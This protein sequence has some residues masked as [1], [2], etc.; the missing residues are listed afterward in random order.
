MRRTEIRPLA[1]P[2]FITSANFAFLR[3]RSIVRVVTPNQAAISSIGCLHH[4]E[5]FQLSHIDLRRCSTL[6]HFLKLLARFTLLAD[7][8]TGTRPKPCQQCLP[9]PVQLNRLFMS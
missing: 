2:R 4:R 6:R 3:L 8:C 1:F 7:L 5:L 9:F